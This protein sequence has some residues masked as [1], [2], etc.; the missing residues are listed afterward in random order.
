M[1]ASENPQ[2]S[3]DYE[4]LINEYHVTYLIIANQSSLVNISLSLLDYFVLSSSCAYDFCS[5]LFHFDRWLVLTIAANLWTLIWS[6][7]GGGDCSLC[8]AFCDVRLSLSATEEL[9]HGVDTR[10]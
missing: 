2:K 9:R 4:D 8:S 10:L 7:V 3:L 5:V 6:G 1:S